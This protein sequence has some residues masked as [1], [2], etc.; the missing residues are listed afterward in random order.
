MTIAV[1]I[2]VG[3]HLLGRGFGQERVP[4]GTTPQVGQSTLLA[5]DIADLRTAHRTVFG[6]IRHGIANPCG[7][8]HVLSLRHMTVT[9]CTLGKKC[10]KPKTA[11]MFIFC[12]HDLA[13]S[14]NRPTAGAPAFA[15]PP[16]HGAVCRFVRP[17]LGRIPFTDLR[18][19]RA[20]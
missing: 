20:A 6:T 19:R 8:Y 11:V 9:A 18:Q 5:Q 17:M 3:Q 4:T 15:P 7:G 2:E 14:R 10:T 16:G 13:W 1:R 12:Y